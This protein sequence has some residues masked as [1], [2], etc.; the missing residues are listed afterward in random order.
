MLLLSQWARGLHPPRTRAPPLGAILIDVRP[1]SAFGAR[2]LHG[3]SSIPLAELEARLFELPA[4]TEDA[5]S[6]CGAD[7]GDLRAAAELLESRG[8]AVAFALDASDEAGWLACAAAGWREAAAESSWSAPSWRPN[9]F[10]RHHLADALGAARDAE[11]AA[12]AA[13]DGPAPRI[14]LDLGA[15]NGRDAVFLAQTLGPGW[16]V[17]AVDNHVGALERCRALAAKAGVQARVRTDARNLRRP[18]PL[19]GWAD[20]RVRLAHGSRFLVKPLLGALRDEVLR[21]PGALFIWSTFLEPGDGEEENR[22]PPFRP[23]RRLRRGELASIFGE[24]SGWRVL[25]DEV[26]E[27]VTRG[28]R[29]PAGFFAAVRHTRGV[30][31]CG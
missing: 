9:L 10:L 12:G 6:L 4:P 1:P 31:G 24:A 15:G 29:V 25:R 21:E 7:G 5:L 23:S 20:G 11:R 19:A 13:A 22:A 30:A 3:A 27:L 17:L 8:W 18:E 26:G 14:A 2:H 16:E 28:E